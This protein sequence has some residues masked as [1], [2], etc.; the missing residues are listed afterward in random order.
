MCLY[1]RLMEFYGVGRQNLVDLENH[2][3]VIVKHMNI[4]SRLG[5]SIEQ[6]GWALN[7]TY[8]FK[9]RFIGF[10]GVKGLETKS[11]WFVSITIL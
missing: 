8:V 10:N 11:L 3:L 6:R 5:T 1:L 7:E 2:S 9:V 4:I